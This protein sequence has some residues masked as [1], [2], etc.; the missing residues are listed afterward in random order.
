M[1]SLSVRRNF[2]TCSFFLLS[3]K[4]LPSLLPESCARYNR[5][6]A[7]CLLGGISPFLSYHLRW[8]VPLKAH[9]YLV[10]NVCRL[11]SPGRAQDATRSLNLCLIS[12]RESC[13][14]T[15]WPLQTRS[16]Q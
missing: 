5:C 2:C 13:G 14:A 7:V 16:C 9:L 10:C 3:V 6:P 1:D 12:E 4:T 15:Q 8:R 11:A